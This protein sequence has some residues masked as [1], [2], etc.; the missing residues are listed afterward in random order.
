MPLNQGC[1]GRID[2]ARS[3]GSH[4]KELQPEDARRL[5]RLNNIRLGLRIG[6]IY[7]GWGPMAATVS[8]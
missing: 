5:L 2:V 7:F 1:E 6:W 8:T 3:T 4:D